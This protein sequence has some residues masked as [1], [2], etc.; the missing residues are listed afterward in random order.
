MID[1]GERISFPNG[2]LR[3]RARAAL[4][5][6]TTALSS[7]L[8]IGSAQSQK[9]PSGGSVAA[10]SVAITQPGTTQLTITQSSPSAIINWQGFSIGQGAA[11]SIQQPSASSALLN[12]VTGSTPSTIAGSLTANG[13]VYLVNPNGIAIT[14]SGVV[15]TVGG[16]VASTLGITDADFLGGK[17]TFTGN[18][19][20]AAVSN[21]GLIR[22]GRGG[23]AAL[24]GG[25]VSNSGRIFVPLGQV[26]LG[27]GESATLDFSG[28]GFLQVALPTKAGGSAALIGNSGTIKAAGGS[29]II[30]AAT[31]REA[32]RN[33][34]NISGIVQAR[35]IGGKS[36]SIFIG[37]GAGGDVNVSGRL[38]A[39]GRQTAGGAITVTG[40]DITLAGA[41]LDASGSSGGGNI[42]IGGGR[43]GRG[44]LQQA[45]TV[46]I[47]GATTIRANATAA[48]NGGNVVVWSNALSTFAGTISAQGGAQGGNGGEA[49]VSGKAKLD[50]RGF[51]DLS[52]ANGQFGTLLLDPYNVIIS[53]GANNT[54]GSFTAN[55]NDSIINAATLQSALGAANVTIT[56]GTGGAQAGNITV[57]APLT[58]AAATTLGLN[59]AGAIA[60]NAPI[61][62][63]GG[64]GL[65]LNATA[66][67]GV[68]TTGLTFGNG[69]SIDYGATDHGG[70]FSLNGTSY[71]LVYSMAQ[72]DAIDGVNAVNGS[73]LTTYG[74]GLA[75]NYALATDLNA[76]GTTYTQALIGTNSSPAAKFSGLFDGLGHTVTGLTINE[77]GSYAGLL[78]FVTGAASVSNI[79]LVG[80][81]VAGQSNI[82]SLVGWLDS[83]AVVQ[84]SFSGA[85]VTGTGINNTGGLIGFNAGTVQSSYASG[86]VTGAYGTGGLVGWN[87]LTVVN[88]YA[89]GAVTG[90]EYTGGLIGINSGSVS[91]SH[92]TGAVTGTGTGATAIDTGGLIGY[93]Q[94]GSVN[95]SYASGAVTGPQ[96][97]GGLIGVSAALVQA[98][99]ATGA[100]KGTGDRTG[101]L[102]AQN[103]GTLQNSFATGAVSGTTKSGGLLGLNSP[104]GTVSSSY[105][106][107]TVTGVVA[108]TG[109]LIGLNNGAANAVTSSYWD[110]LTSGLATSAGGVGV[111][112]LTTAQLQGVLP[113]GF[114]NTVWSTGAGLYPY[115]NWQFAAGTTP[116]S[117]SGIAHQANGTALAGAVLA[118]TVNGAAF[119]G[120]TGA[121]GYY[122][123]LLPQGTTAQGSGIFIDI[124]GNAV[125]ANDYVH[126]AFGSLQ[127][128]DLNAGALNV[129]T[130]ATAL[131]SLASVLAG[132]VGSTPPTDLVFSTPGGVLTPK[133]A[134]SVS[135]AASG[136]FSVDQNLVVPNA[137]VLTAAGSLT[138]ASTGSLS[139]SN[140]NVTLVDG[141]TFVNN[142]GA[143]AV[144]AANGRW[145]IYS[146]DPA[147]D[148]RGGFAYDFKQYGATYGVT[149]VAQATGNG[150][151][152]T[153]TPTIGLTGTASKT[154][155]GNTSVAPGSFSVGFAGYDQDLITLTYSNLVYGDANA[156]TGKNVTA[157]GVA[158]TSATNGGA[159][160]YGYASTTTAS[161]NIGIIAARALT[162]T[163]DAQSRIYGNVNPALSYTVGSGLISGDSLSGSL[164][165][166]AT[167]T[168]GIG[169]YGIT[170][171]SLANSNYALTYAA[172]NLTITARP[173]TVTA[174]AQS[175][176]YGNVNPALSYTIGGSGL[177]N[178]DSLNGT[179]STSATV[180]T[181]VGSDG[182]TQGSVAA[183][184][185]YA[186]S[187]TGSSLAIT[188][189]PLTVTADA[190]SRVYG[191]ANPTLS[192]TVGGSGL[193][194]GDSLNGTLATSAT[195]ATGVGSYGITQGS[196]AASSN[197]ALS[198]TGSSLAITARPITV[199]ADAQSRIYGNAN[200]TLSYTVGGSG[201]VNG[202]SLS[203]TL[204]TTATVATGIGSYGITQGTLANSNY[205]LSYTGANL[206]ITTRALTVTANAPSRI[207]GDANPA[208]SYTISGSGL[209]NGDGL[210]GSLATTATV[211]TG[212]GSYGITQGSVAASSNYALSYTGSSVAITAR[213]ITV[214]ADAQSR[215]YG[216]ANPAL[217]YTV[218]G[219]GLV[220]G[221][222]LSGSLATTAMVATGVGSYGITQGSVAASSNYALSYTGASLAITARPIA[223]TADAQSRVYG[224]A[225]PALTYTVGPL[226]LVNGD[227]LAGSLGTDA[228]P[229]S[230]AG[231][232]TITQGTLINALNPNYAIAYAGATLVVGAAASPSSPAAAATPSTS[233]FI[234]ATSD[235]S[236]PK[237]ASINFQP[238][239][240]ATAVIAP[241]AVTPAR[242]ASKSD[243]AT[244]TAARQNADDDIVTGSI[245]PQAFKS[246]DGFVYKPLS[247]YDAAQY[248]GK[249]LP[250]FE[251]QAGEAA[252]F[253]MLLRGALGL[254][255]MPKIDNLYEPGTGLQWRGANWENPLADKVRVS[256]GT[257]HTAAPGESFPIRSGTTDLAVLLSKGPLILTGPPN[258]PNAAP[259]SLLAV[260]MSEEGIVANDPGTGLQVLL[261]YNS[262]TKTL[263][264]I[265][266][267]F[268]SKTKTWTRLADV[269]PNNDK[270][271]QAQLDRLATWSGDRFTSVSVPHPVP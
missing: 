40:K 256:D 166:T 263:G 261:D 74:A 60:I 220:N 5:L 41:T 152:Y 7:S 165:T 3:R 97:V 23:Y 194:N 110:T 56:T 126:G 206:A 8:M 221:D 18:G 29:I 95:A 69:A 125:K 57:A 196:V 119:V 122:Y 217:T 116:Q 42:N 36:G 163:A 46:T 226:G 183:S 2:R 38:S 203:G 80:G 159:T 199:T 246:A 109:G 102:I 90:V 105:A 169:S 131:S 156:G 188:A 181:G 50:Y 124:A 251:S 182:I 257:D 71:T 111:A 17:R 89:T 4:L 161:G 64:G 216:N 136:A 61:S 218:G 88:S 14:P 75:S 153:V 147:N 123:L 140:G 49:E 148:S 191:N 94:S 121:N 26:G 197:Y 12:R 53:S 167:A 27:S 233:P 92:A 6:T 184:S 86:P 253:T 28:D 268:D 81:S 151:L 13:Q 207:Y 59:A 112:G 1:L 254:P 9:L 33:A 113:T 65:A 238:D 271:S 24:L 164:A 186:L 20:S 76:A 143:A 93:H 219:S 98:S 107:G 198:Y 157:N 224:N 234:V 235:P 225:N 266:S 31:A 200:P 260:T 144:S 16:F 129:R 150:V 11:V 201:L 258:T 96:N 237:Q 259:A 170:L 63:T 202:D 154:Y 262:K 269:K 44:P 158:V 72:L 211:A 239:Q 103:L 25:T 114:S 128:L 67:A 115:L 19:A 236:T 213:P 172:A 55:T 210:S 189:R 120:A 228:T 43:Q 77:P 247:Q 83:G 37:G 252:I 134:T 48:G 270:Q 139:S 176:I 79:G 82:G 10:G 249:T 62:I 265:L 68:T 78:G 146:G 104:G 142:A 135:I 173:I 106:T 73:A 22:V 227:T 137:L 267:V 230:G 232:Y 101:G 250:G 190:Q 108:S 248:S 243:Q 99:Y 52:A 192:Y 178:G 32:A 35:S 132:V 205:A 145:L 45:D 30:S 70:T 245:T 171:G 174:D 223:V 204:A 84:T 209:V 127:N 229:L 160:V 133:A 264:S 187:Y 51:T 162:V 212:V 85:A 91:G 180:L 15:S 240:F 208:L 155:D 66:Q 138:I 255:D 117:L 222:S 34:V 231:P 87:T 100:V 195:V 54:G 214:T 130:D 39:S 193:V 242:V 58:W 149:A 177:A 241:L 185:N 215:I 179:L 168:T 244:Q 21:A 47:D 141:S 175:R 118:G